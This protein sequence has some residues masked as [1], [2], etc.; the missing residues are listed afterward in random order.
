MRKGRFKPREDRLDTEN[1]RTRSLNQEERILMTG[2]LLSP[3]DDTTDW[4][5]DPES[6][7]DPDIKDQKIEIP[8]IL[9]AIRKRIL[10]ENLKI[11]ITKKAYLLI[12]LFVKGNPGKAMFVLHKIGNF[13]EKINAQRWLFTSRV[14]T[15]S[16]FPFG[17]PTEGAFAKWWNAQKISQQGYSYNKVD[18][19]PDE[20]RKK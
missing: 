12:L 11:E 18:I 9:R 20:W 3:I 6:R 8:W 2:I 10:D 13:F 17:F 4:V 19:F 16:L 14:F 5:F 1:L 7:F 15:C